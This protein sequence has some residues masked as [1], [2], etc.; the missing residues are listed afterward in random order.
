MADS[1]ATLLTVACQAPLSMRFPW[2]EHWSGLP[3]L[4]PGN[5]PD[6]GIEHVS[7]ALTG[8]FFTTEP[9]G[10]SQSL[11]Y[12]LLYAIKHICTHAFS[13]FLSVYFWD[14]FL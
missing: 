1:F 5:P 12:M 10:K 2:Q 14:R 11:Y 7:P 13:K 6:P 8:G 9:P 3:F 4:P